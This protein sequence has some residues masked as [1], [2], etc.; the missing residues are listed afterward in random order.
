MKK[1]IDFP[2][3]DTTFPQPAT[4]FI[5]RK[6]ELAD[7]V[8][9]LANATCRLVTLVG[10]GGIGKT[11]LALQAATA[12]AGSF[13]HGAIFVPLQAVR[14]PEFLPAAVSEALS[15]SSSGQGSPRASLLNYLN[16]K[17][18]LLVLDNFEQLLEGADLL[19]EIMSA[20][21]DVKILVTSRQVLNLREEW[22]YPVHGLSIPPAGETAAVATYGAVQLFEERA[23]Q[24]RPT[25]SLA[26]EA[27]G[28]V[29]I[30]RLVGGMP[31]ALELAASWVKTLTC[32]DIA[33]EI[34]HD[35]NFL[36]SSLRDMPPRHRSML[37]VFHQTWKQLSSKEQQI[38]QQLSIFHG[39]FS[40]EAAAQIAG[41]SLPTLSAL[42]DKSL[43]RR[44]PDG[45]YQIHE[46]LRQY[47]AEQL[48]QTPQQV[49]A[50][51]E[52]HCAYYTTF[53]HNHLDAVLGS[54]QRVAF[55]E[56]HAELDNIR[57]AWQWAVDHADTT[58]ILKSTRTLEAFYQARSYFVEG[59]SALQK[60]ADSLAE[61]AARQEQL[62]LALVLVCLGWFYIRLGKYEAAETAVTRSQ[63]LY[64]TLDAIPL[65]GLGMDPLTALAVLHHIRGEYATAAGL[66]ARA[67]R[68]NETRG[69]RYNLATA[70]YLLAG[71]FLAQGKCEEASRMAQRACSMAEEMGNRWF[72]AYALIEWGN[73]ARA[74]QD[75]EEARQHYQASHEI[76]AA[77]D[78]D[79]EGV[80][81]ALNHLGEIALLQNAYEEA[82]QHYRRSFALYQ[83]LDDKGGLAAALH[84]LGQA[85]CA[86]GEYE[87][88][89]QYLHE[90][91][92]IA[93]EIHYVSLTL[94]LLAA[95]GNLFVR[96]GKA[97]YGLGVLSLAAHH[98]A[99]EH[100]TRQQAQQWLDDYRARLSP[101]LFA[102]TTKNGRS[103]PLEP[104]VTAV[105]AELATLTISAGEEMPAI[106]G[107]PLIDPL[108]E[109]E[110]EV[111]H[112]IAGGMTNRQIA[113]TLVIST[114]TVKWYSGQIYSKLQVSNRTA[115]VSRA[116]ELNIL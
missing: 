3:K 114:G 35:L 21:P 98:T 18:M 99:G 82:Q 33:A 97:A 34:A 90:A 16:D 59:A 23:R 58:A 30:C 116:R 70:C 56:I 76:R 45:R 96:A 106:A 47:A 32:A 4:S 12:V 38:F 7:I 62:A 9:L 6:A 28:V 73:A 67:R 55:T 87:T 40:R 115:A 24:V 39:G 111:L 113:E 100:E 104:T 37:A 15:L 92:S 84:G 11:R 36:E 51:H 86:L 61:G 29:R 65:P 77:F 31:L 75:Y 53:L 46:L 1:K 78:D 102:T 68:Q 52:R 27:A 88:A 48:A 110:L 41:A 19:A 64:T 20:A 80:A 101:A 83:K 44:Q 63:E 95:A 72:L 103:Q 13:P 94:S 57:A 54:E 42:L 81:T 66:G 89:R 107:Q 50:V 5:G 69:D 14:A 85:A 74:M 43:L 22:L 60:A 25:F 109:R 49:N 91:L 10:A 2:T 93:H 112:H 8:S 71:T 79:P 105:L 17:K 108:T 26:E